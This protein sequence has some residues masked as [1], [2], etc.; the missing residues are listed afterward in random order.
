MMLNI[1]LENALLTFRAR[2]LDRT[3]SLSSSRGDP[4]PRGS[5]S[6]FCVALHHHHAATGGVGEAKVVINGNPVKNP[7]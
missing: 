5:T 7:T 4:S 6:I 3:V 2:T 1:R